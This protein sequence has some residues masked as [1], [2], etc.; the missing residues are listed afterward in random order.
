MSFATVIFGTDG[1]AGADRALDLARML[2]SDSGGHL[3]VVHAEEL[4]L[5]GKASG[6]FPVHAN[7]PELRAKIEDQVAQASA[8]GID[9]TLHS[10]RVSAG[11]AAHVIAD[12]A[13]E[14]GADVIVVGTRGHTP[15]GGLLV[16]S[17][18]QRLLH[19]APCPVLV[20]PRS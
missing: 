4:T 7:E 17:V 20:V 19:I 2:A 8:A 16:G 14:M 18:A 10:H 13:G 5:P 3:H 12:V 6:R 9:T 1:S 11:G 15:L